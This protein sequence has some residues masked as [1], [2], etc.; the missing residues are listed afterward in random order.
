MIR[1]STNDLTC[2]SMHKAL[3]PP[4]CNRRGTNRKFL[5]RMFQYHIFTLTRIRTRDIMHISCNHYHCAT[6]AVF[7]FEVKSEVLNFTESVK[8]AYSVFIFLT[9]FNRCLLLI[10]IKHKASLIN[11]HILSGI[12][13]N[14]L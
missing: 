9:D 11:L 1:H 7:R 8:A 2:F 6:E 3:A 14:F 12:S 4:T 5:D 10:C 13:Q